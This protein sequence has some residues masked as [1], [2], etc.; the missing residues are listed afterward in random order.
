MPG[1]LKTGGND[2]QEPAQTQGLPVKS[3]SMSEY[4]AGRY[5]VESGRVNGQINING[6]HEEAVQNQ[7]NGIGKATS[8]LPDPSAAAMNQRSGQLPPEIEH[9]TFGYLPV[10]SLITRLVQETFN[11]L[12]DVISDM[13]DS[14]APLVNG[15]AA[16]DDLEANEQ[17][18]LRL[19]DFAQEKRAQFIKILVL[20]QWGRQAESMGRVIDLKVWLDRQRKLFDDACNWMGE[21]K[22]LI[23]LERMP[24]PDLKTALETLSLGSA[25]RLPDLKYMPSKLLPPQR[26]LKALRSI[27]TQLSIKLNLHLD[28]PPSLRDFS[29]ANG[30]VTF[31]VATEFELDLSIADDDPSSQLYFIDF[32]FLLSSSPAMIPPSRLRDD[33]E[34]KVNHLLGQGEL[35]ECY[36]FLHDFVLSHKLSILKY[37]AYRMSQGS[38]SEQIRVEAVHRSLVIQY[39]ICRPGDKNWIEIG[40]RRR[41][42]KRSSWLHDED[43]PHIGLRW[44]RA[45]KEVKDIPLDVDMGTLSS[46]AILK[47]V[48]SAHTDTIFKVISA[49]M[50]EGPLYQGDHLRLRYVRC[51]AEPINSHL[52]IQLT[53][54]K[55]CKIVQEPVSGRLSLQPPSSLHS[56]AERELNGLR[57]LEKDASSRIAQLRA[58]ASF[59]EVEHTARCIGWETVSSFRPS[60]DT[61]KSHFGRDTLKCGFFRRASWRPRWLMVF[62][63]SLGQDA[64]WIC[65]L[66][67]RASNPDQQASG[68]SIRATH[69]I[70][71]R[72]YNFTV[73][74]LVPAELSR[75]EHT[76]AGS[77]SHMMD[78]RLLAAQKIPHRFVGSAQSTSSLE[79]PILYIS[80]KKK[81]VRRLLN[82]DESTSLPWVNQ[83]VRIVFLGVD[84]SK[85]LAS[86]FVLARTGCSALLSEPLRSSLGKSITIHPTSSVFAFRLMNPVGQSTIPTAL[87]RLARVELLVAHV[88]TLQRLKMRSRGLSLDEVEFTYATSPQDFC[89]KMSFA[90]DT[91]P[92]LSFSQGNPHLRIK[93]QLAAVLGDPDCLTHV[94]HYLQLSLPLM[95]AFADMEAS[96]THGQV[97]VLPRSAEWYCIQY[98]MPPARFDVRLRRRRDELMW[99]VHETSL[100]DGQKMESQVRDQIDGLIKGKGEGWLG[101][102]PGM[103]AS[104]DG[105]RVLLHKI[106]EIFKSTSTAGPAPAGEDKDY[107]GTKRKAEDKGVITLD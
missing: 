97:S 46:E 52:N 91:R 72:G 96:D 20:L 30:R 54:S 92:K 73:D 86:H 77:I 8:M 12:T 15:A 13:S 21:L 81:S 41:K 16:A 90:R 105:V 67:N 63:S 64:W 106:N 4:K 102:R 85:T 14:G 101:V 2:R 45:G 7:T 69:R 99:Y 61:I 34:A 39:W 22:R 98:Q 42:A 62:T 55:S 9:I 3:A 6:I 28:I 50:R 32:R 88:T 18:K 19:L 58:I 93:H 70:L 43:Q 94:I 51:A 23:G 48:I 74:H 84:S 59:E 83:V 27:N 65:E 26:L 76:A 57:S 78:S 38:W 24:S 87:D 35:K 10:S 75:V 36:D 40:L 95:L 89:A 49:K 71:R 44:F 107:K 104:L 1:V 82:S 80:L 47:Q 17:K 37:Q 66:D 11:G 79:L 60:Q 56:R 100:P 25:P 29:V 103:T 53:A 31:R 33:I 5:D 68:M